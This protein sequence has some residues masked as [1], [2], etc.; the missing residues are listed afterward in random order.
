[1]QPER[2]QTLQID[3]QGRR[4]T[5]RFGDREETHTLDSAEGFELVSH[6]WVKSG[7]EAQYIYSFTW[8]G[9]PIIQLPDDLVRMQEVIYHL[10]PDVIVETGVAHGGSLIFYA[11]LFKAMGHPGRVIGVDI[12]IRAHNRK[13]IEEHELFSYLELLEGSSTAPEIVAEV[14]RRVPKDSRVL[15]ILDS[16]HTR[17]HVLDELRAY[18]DLVTPGSW[19][20]STDGVMEDLVGS[21]RSQPDWGWNNPRQAAEDFLQERSDFQLKWPE[22]V[23]N[24][25]STRKPVTHWPGAWL[26]K[27][28]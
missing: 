16:N 2:P 28:V 4:V 15:V 11:S 14:Y 17:D 6:A 1:M 18:A 8:M 3:L 19:I 9:R 26:Q 24:E 7:W 20:V 25:G 13:A 22:P 21:P 10:K 27:K 23:F 5:A 12:E